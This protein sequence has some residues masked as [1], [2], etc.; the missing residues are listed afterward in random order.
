MPKPYIGNIIKYM[1]ELNIKATT[2]N[3]DEVLAFVNAELEERDCSPKIQM[4]IEVAVEELFVNIAS[5][6]YAPEIGNATVRLEA[7]D[8]PHEIRITFMDEGVPYD[9]LKKEDPDITLAADERRIGGYGIYIVKKTMDDV[10]YEHKDGKN[11]TMI[12]KSLE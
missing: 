5:Y 6:A 11:I 9:P 3:L 1:K 12:I 2:D 7:L 4:Q 8:E 10:Q